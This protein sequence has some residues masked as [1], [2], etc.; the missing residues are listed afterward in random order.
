MGG[1][2]SSPS[3]LST[4]AT[5]ACHAAD[6]VDSGGSYCFQCWFRDA[7]SGTVTFDFTR[8]SLN[9][10]AAWSEVAVQNWFQDQ[11]HGFFP[12][13]MSDNLALTLCP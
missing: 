9:Q 8:F 6:K 13:D 7:V 5:S 4:R 12:F 1:H 10:L 11:A 2:Y 3:S